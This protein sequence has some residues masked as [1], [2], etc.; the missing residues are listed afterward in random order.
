MHD[1][2][3]IQEP[4]AS[5]SVG[6]QTSPILHGIFYRI[7]AYRTAVFSHWRTPVSTCAQIFKYHIRDSPLSRIAGRGFSQLFLTILP[8]TEPATRVM[9]G[10]TLELYP[11]ITWLDLNAISTFFWS[12]LSSAGYQAVSSLTPNPPGFGDKS[13]YILIVPS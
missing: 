10:W 7:D 11:E 2:G 4:P 3:K 8:E 12:K 5:A 6:W 9:E 1:T 13:Q